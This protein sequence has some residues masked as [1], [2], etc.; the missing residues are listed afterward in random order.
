MS[1]QLNSDREQLRGVDST[2]IGSSSVRIRA[3]QGTEEREI[4]QTK[5]DTASGLPRVGINRTGRRVD[6]IEVTSAGQNYTDTPT[7]EISAPTLPGGVQAV[8]SATTDSFG[9]ITS[10][11]IDNQGDG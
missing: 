11:G 2:I 6:F 8:A 5:V 1:F 4:F 9:R 10:I 3:G 7:V